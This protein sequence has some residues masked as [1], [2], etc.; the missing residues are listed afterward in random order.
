MTSKSTDMHE[1]GWNFWKWPEIL[2]KIV[3]LIEEMIQKVKK[4]HFSK[5]LTTYEKDNKK[6]T[7]I[8]IHIHMYTYTYIAKRQ[9]IKNIVFPL[10]DRCIITLTLTLMCFPRNSWSSHVFLCWYMYIYIY[11]CIFS[12]DI[13]IF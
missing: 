7:Y 6:L 12:I 11:I 2:K 4:I 8:Y 5:K 9:L 10:K 3:R 13:F 1:D